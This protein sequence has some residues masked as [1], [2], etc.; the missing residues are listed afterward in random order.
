M[1]LIDRNDIENW[2]QCFDSKGNFPTLVSRLVRA[3]TPIDTQADFPSGSAAFVGGWD[4]IVDAAMGTGFVPSGTSLWELGTESDC[5]GKAEKD[6]EKRSADPLGYNAENC[7]FIFVT[8][9]FW[10]DKKKWVDAKRKLKIWKDVRVY[11]SS[12]L[13]QWLDSAAAVSRWFS[14]YLRKYPYDGILT[15]EEFW[16]E[17]TLGDK[18]ELPSLIFTSGRDVEKSALLEFLQGVPGIIAVQASSKDEAIAF[19]IAAATEFEKD[20]KD[21]FFSRSLIIQDESNFRSVRINSSKLNLIADFENQQILYAAAAEEHHV[22]LPLGPEDSSNQKTIILPVVDR[23]GFLEGLSMSNISIEDAERYSKE[24]ARS[25]TV[26]KRLLKFPFNKAKWLDTEDLGEII[27]ALMVGRWKQSFKGDTQIIEKL[28]G[29]SYEAYDQIL[30]KWKNLEDSPIIQIGDAWRL[31]SPLDLWSALASQVRKNVYI[32]FQQLVIATFRDRNPFEEENANT[33]VFPGFTNQKSK[34]SSWAKEGLLQSL[35]LIGVYGERF[36]I[37]GLGDCQYWVD[38]TI[39]ELFNDVDGEL[40]VLLN[41]QMPLIAEASPDTFLEAVEESL[42]QSTPS[43]MEMFVEGEGFIG[44]S[45]NHTG[46]L[47]ALEGLCWMPEHLSR[48]TSILLLLAKLD[49]GGSVVNR[50]INSLAEVFRPW[51]YQTLADF[52]GRMNSLAYMTHCEK[53]VGWSLL[54]KLLPEPHPVSYSNHKLRWRTF[55]QNTNLDYTWE[56]IGK[57]NSF[58]V[59][60][61]LRIFDFSESKL[62]ELLRASTS[63]D[64][65]DR[66]DVMHFAVDISSRVE[67]V[68]FL[69]W[70]SVREI[71]GHHRSFPDMDWALPEQALIPYQ[72]LYYRLQPQDALM[73]NLWLFDDEFPE[74]PEGTNEEGVALTDAYEQKEIKT[75]LARKKAIEEIVTEFGLDGVSSLVCLSKMPDAVGDALAGMFGKNFDVADFVDMVNSVDNRA[76]LHGFIVRQVSDNGQ[77]WVLDLFFQ[78]EKLSAS[79]E[80]LSQILMAMPQT[81]LLWEF[82]STQPAGI[83][84]LYWEKMRPQ[85]HLLSKP[86]IEQGI[87]KLNQYGRY[88]SAMK[89]CARYLEKIPTEL[90]VNSMHLAG[91][92]KAAEAITFREYDVWGIFE[93][94][95]KRQDADLQDIVTL[96][97][98]Y[99]LTLSSR[100][101]RR[102]PRFLHDELSTNPESFVDTLKLVYT[103][104]A[105]ERIAAEREGLS[106]E[107]IVNRAVA[108]HKLLDSWNRLPGMRDDHTIDERFLSDWIAKVRALAE[109][110]DR[111]NVADSQIGKILAAYPESNPDWPPAIICSVIE[112]IN[113]E[114]LREGYSSALF[115]N[116]GSSVRGQFDG[117]DI[118]RRHAEHFERNALK[119]KITFP[120]VANIFTRLAKGYRRE[121]EQM[122]QSAERDKLEY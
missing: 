13:E 122:D 84:Q 59:Q 72:D 63:L 6:F 22:L 116:R 19:V 102:S 53:E 119:L 89:T 41:R 67:Q 18:G 39:K 103:P 1:R 109:A 98:I 94:L 88:V 14:S 32:S 50:P 38:R 54:L 23:K 70:N 73:R 113:T 68:E 20:H 78:A 26:L 16:K 35:V 90:I 28:S 55:E 2:A 87:T 108:G 71:L 62:S 29:M 47:W 99:L 69:A 37:K 12:D 10:R 75:N 121:A 31:K 30:L 45:A 114:R 57:T 9:R 91:S 117:G 120:I 115:N 101:T 80:S 65:Q 100:H 107:L 118:E 83:Q 61:M 56:E 76:F 106:D 46:L 43:I 24:S 110:A 3:T 21:L 17:Y 81:E 42:R 95:D 5:K 111:L 74:H 112:T 86:G 104:Q 33:W 7:T 66:E 36:N 4:G 97:W 64:D 96:E 58:I 34:F 27:P 25:V 48:A 77:P 49:P 11:D 105:E 52:E 60:Q 82:L 92:K 51:H 93:E 44:P 40:W 85:F 79:Q 8:P 15:I